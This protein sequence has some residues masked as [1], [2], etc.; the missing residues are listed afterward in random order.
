MERRAK[1]GEKKVGGGGTVYYEA[2]EELLG[3]SF[4]K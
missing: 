2:E 1:A 4:W 3:K